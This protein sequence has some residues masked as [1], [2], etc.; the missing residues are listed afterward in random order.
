MRTLRRYFAEEQVLV[1]DG[2]VVEYGNAHN[3]S[4]FCR[5]S[6]TNLETVYC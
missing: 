6:T 5:P 1:V 2:V 4:T 3:L